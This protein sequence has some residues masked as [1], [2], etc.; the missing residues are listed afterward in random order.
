M[1]F[2][3]WAAVDQ[4]GET[5]DFY[6]FMNQGRLVV[7]ESEV[8]GKFNESG[9][10]FG[11]FLATGDPTSTTENAPNPVDGYGFWQDHFDA[12]YDMIMNDEVYWIRVLHNA[13][14][15][16]NPPS[17]ADAAAWHEEWPNSKILNVPDS[18]C[19]VSPYVGTGWPRL[20]L[21]DENL[22]FLI[23]TNSG[24]SEVL[25]FLTSQTDEEDE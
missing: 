24:P 10:A 2:P 22:H 7:I 19:R 13:N 9:N 20:D 4:Y 8:A 25:N 23:H 15:E 5:V 14:C 1:A 11:A 21:L 12:V 16:A 6:D 18:E 17:Q 3:R